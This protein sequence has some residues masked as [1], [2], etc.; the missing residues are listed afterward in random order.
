MSEI[1]PEAQALLDEAAAAYAKHNSEETKA[2][3]NEAL[4]N[5]NATIITEKEDGTA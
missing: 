1:T 5:I 3:W 2:A 4:G